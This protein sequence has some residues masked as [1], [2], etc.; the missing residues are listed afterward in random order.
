[1]IRKKKRKGGGRERRWLTTM[2]NSATKA[3]NL[4]SEK[5]GIKKWARQNRTREEVDEN[6]Y[7]GE[8]LE[9]RLFDTLLF[10]TSVTSLCACVLAYLL[11]ACFAILASLLI[12]SLRSFL[13]SFRP[14][15]LFLSFPAS[16]QCVLLNIH[17]AYLTPTRD[18]YTYTY[19]YG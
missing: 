8:G 16:L 14:S 9:N 19:R 12:F 10:V 17:G 5:K 4:E 18:Y 2:K 1:M 3:N 7:R 13:P 11:V 15:T 6:F